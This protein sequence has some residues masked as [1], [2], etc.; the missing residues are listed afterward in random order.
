MKLALPFV[1][2]HWKGL[3]L[4][5][6][7]ILTITTSFVSSSTTAEAP[8]TTMSTD[9]PDHHRNKDENK[10][11]DISI[12][13]SDLDGTLLHYPD[14]IPKSE[15]GNQL[16]KLPPSSTGMRGIISSQTLARIQQIRNHYN[17]NN[18][19]KKD[20]KFVLVSGMRTSTF[21]NR[22]P[23]LPKADA[24]C[25]EAGGRIF[26]PTTTAAEGDST[27]FVVK[28]KNFDGA[29]DDDLSP[30]GIK[31]DLEWR[32][33]QEKV[34]G[35]YE[36]PDLKELAKNPAQVK[37]LRER[38][39]LL[40]DFARDLVHKGYVLDTNGYSACFRVNRKQQDAMSDDDFDALLDGRIKPFEGLA[41]SVNLS[42]VDYYPATSGKKN[43]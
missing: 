31:E 35:P 11:K 18:N 9:R 22:L 15:S 25:T 38:D 24:Y 17:H 23:F 39:G 12:V 33:M 34:A 37:E 5:L 7:L 42:C 8:P 27:A 28:P 32:V 1:Y 6:V 10:V 40:W 4:A 16:L 43:W 29:T 30:F 13:F 21:L 20:V 14:K 19:N 26:Y 41:S 3:G 2:L 36:S